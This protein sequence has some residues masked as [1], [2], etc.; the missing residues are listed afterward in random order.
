ANA[1]NTIQAGNDETF[2]P[3]DEERYVLINSTGGFEELTEDKFRF[4]NGGKELRIFGLNVAGSARLIATMRKINVTNKVKSL[5][6][7][8]SIIVNKS[9]LSASGIGS[10][11]LDDGLTY[12]SYGYGLRVQDKEICLLEPDVTKVY[13][14][15]E[16]NDTNNPTLPTINLFNLDGPTGKVDD[17][18]V[19]E[20]ILGSASGASALYVEK[21]GTS[22]IGLVYL[23]DLRFEVGESIKSETSGI[24]GTISDFDPGDENIIDR[25]SL[26]SGQRETICDYSRLVRKPNTKDP[27]RKLRVIY[28]S[29]AYSDSTEGDITTAS[30]Y[31]QFKYCELPLIKN[32]EKL[33][34]ILDIRP[35]VRKFDSSSTN[36]SPFEFSSR[37]FA[38]GTNSAKNILASDESIIL[39]Y[40]HYL[41]RIDKLYLK[42]DGGFQ[43][44]KGVPAETP[45]P[46]LTLEDSLE[47]ATINLPPYICNTE[48]IQITLNSYKRYRMQD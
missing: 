25:F 23:N 4:S 8:N 22:S 17:F 32:N 9:K 30:S 38:D 27:R 6:R 44:I 48:N 24:S 20:E 26:D 5:N 13:A 47:V 45:L 46:P 37:S 40:S 3:F 12:G 21:T 33:T 43:L 41:P 11:T 31:N 10:T 15:Y 36:Y 35:R 19:G 14:V 28:E 29:A 1:T 42:L 39:T 16:A 2:L 18:I 34:D 7:T